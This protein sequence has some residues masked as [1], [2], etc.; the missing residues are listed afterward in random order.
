MSMKNLVEKL[1][2]EDASTVAP[3]IKRT[4]RFEPAADAME[5]MKIAGVVSVT[6][7]IEMPAEEHRQVTFAVT[8]VGGK[9]LL[10]ALAN[11]VYFQG[12]TLNGLVNR[13]SVALDRMRNDE[14]SDEEY[15]DRI[16]SL[17]EALQRNND[18]LDAYAAALPQLE[19]VYREYTGEAWQ[20]RRGKADPSTARQTAARLEAEETL[21]RIREKAEERKKLLGAPKP[22]KSLLRRIF[23]R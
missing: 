23:D 21:R 10:D 18:N 12:R 15:D 14:R 1:Q 5:Q 13:Q 16:I 8:D 2:Q 6:I 3:Q 17:N 22:K 20:P 11:D 4:S 19:D 7:A 9:Y